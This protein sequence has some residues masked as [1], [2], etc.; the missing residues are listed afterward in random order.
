MPL[1][2][3]NLG[4]SP[5][6][7][8]GD[9]LRQAF[10]KLDENFQDV[11]EIIEDITRPIPGPPGPLGPTGPIG[12]TGMR[13]IIAKVYSSVAELL[14]DTEPVGIF[15]GQFAIVDTGDPY[16]SENSDL[17]LFND[18]NEWEFVA[19]LAGLQGPT[20]STGPTGPSDGPT[21]P[22]GPIGEAGE[23][24]PPGD[25]GGPTGPTGPTGATGPTGSQGEVGSAGITGATGSTGPTGPLGTTGPTGISGPTGPTGPRGLQGA[26]GP[27][28]Q[29]GST[30]P[31]GFQ[32]NLGATGPLGPTGP[33][34]ATGPRGFIGEL[35]P[36]GPTGSTGPV[37][38]VTISST[39]PV[40]PVIG[41][42][43]WSSVTGELYI[44]YDD[45]SSQQWVYA[46][47]GNIGPTGPSGPS[48]PAGG[49]STDSNAQ[50]NSLGVGTAAST[51]TGEIRATN[52][53]TAYFSDD[54]LKTR[55]GL[56][57]DALNKV[58][59]L[60]GFYYSENEKAKELGY[61]NDKLQVGVSAQEVERVLPEVVVSAPI[62]GNYPDADYKTV[63]YEK[64]IPLL[65][66][67]IKELDE[68]VDRLV[69]SQSS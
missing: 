34:G 21:G 37:Q 63:Q 46:A 40:S 8:G 5:T 69:L 48:G 4:N 23:P 9:N 68:K 67:A 20:G 55:Y 17:Y 14:L 38:K 45:G 30:G 12:E 56:V 36:T 65:I 54:R 25:P 57:E 7:E 50:V 10:T 42:L 59:T 13:F 26:T 62:N 2:S 6:G 28:G 41:D 53:I 11:L 19:N 44:R 66:E 1:D 51:V 15:S 32:G 18:A 31:T 33:T 35:G 47:V 27:T 22:T 64:L 58:N 16:N 52:N 3:V 39:P 60:S 29:T 61:N 24:G 43:W 49:F